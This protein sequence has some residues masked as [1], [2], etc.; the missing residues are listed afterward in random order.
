MEVHKIVVSNGAE[1][2]FIN[3]WRNTSSGFKH[4]TEVFR[5]DSYLTNRS[6]H[7]LNRTWE[8]YQF[9]S[10]MRNAI[11][12]LLGWMLKE[13]LEAYKEEHD[14]KRWNEALKEEVTQ[15]CKQQ[16]RWKEYQELL[17]RL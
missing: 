17:N 1:Y 4:T 7:Y 16:D 14:I 12:D 10:V 6:N 15:A 9:Q 13:Y 5:D 8:S 11:N 3:E 2:R